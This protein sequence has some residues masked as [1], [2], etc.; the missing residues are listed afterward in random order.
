MIKT[1][2][3]YFIMCDGCEAV[4]EHYGQPVEAMTEERASTFACLDNWQCEKNKHLCPLCSLK[5]KEK[6]P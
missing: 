4:H 1:I 5:Q 2:F 3:R 6:K